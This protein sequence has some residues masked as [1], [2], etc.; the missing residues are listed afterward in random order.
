M[1]TLEFVKSIVAKISFKDW[2]F[3]VEDD[4][5][6][7]YVQCQFMDKDFYTGE[8]TLQSCRKFRISKHA[9]E[10]TEVVRDVHKAIYGAMMHDVDEQFK[11]DAVAIYHPH[12]DLAVLVEF[13]KR[14]KIKVREDVR[15]N[16]QL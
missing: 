2:T 13:A 16:K 10:D 15:K 12:F 11:Y 8:M 4:G 1:L 6:S 14:K 5:N 3:R 7:F 9:A